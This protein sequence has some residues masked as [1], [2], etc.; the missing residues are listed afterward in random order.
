[1]LLPLAGSYA[2]TG[3]FKIVPRVCFGY[4]AL[5]MLV[6]LAVTGSHGGWLA[7][8]CGLCLFFAFIL[9]QRAYRIIGVASLLVILVGAVTFAWH[10][11]KTAERRRESPAIMAGRAPWKHIWPVAWRVWKDHPWL[12][13]G[14]RGFDLHYRQYREPTPE[15]QLRPEY[16]HNDYLNLLAD[17]GLVGACLLAG[18]IGC[19]F[20]GVVF[21]WRFIARKPGDL[22]QKKSNKSAFVLGA[23]LGLINL[24]VF[25]IYD[26]NMH[27]P[28]NAI[29]AVLLLAMVSGHLRFATDRFWLP[30]KS[31]GR[32]LAVAILGVS[33]GYLTWQT[34]SLASEQTHLRRAR[35]LAEDPQ[36]QIEALQAAFRVEPRNPETA[37]AIG[38]N[39]RLQG[40]LAPE[41]EKGLAEAALEWY[42]RVPLLNPFD[43][44]PH[45]RI[46][47]CLHTLGRTDEAREAFQ[48]A[49]RLDPNGL[50]TL[51]HVGWHYLQLGDYDTARTVFLKVRDLQSEGM[52][53]AE[54]YLDVIEQRLHTGHNPGVL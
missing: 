2:I 50:F 18:T 47:M 23:S 38:E 10:E 45:L 9:R 46:G 12:G 37:Y 30:Q 28:A 19:F 5:M 8:G 43:P 16:A 31:Y 25:S 48:R 44:Y 40:W 54:P 17:H 7:V 36:A 34:I 53:V 20:W 14:P 29:V 39:L 4:A 33:L 6:G 11:I 3:R 1:M 15:Q 32:P 49:Q 24:M 51:A 42:Q 22:N 41:R 13:A 26:F 21:S 52:E 35:Q 27:I